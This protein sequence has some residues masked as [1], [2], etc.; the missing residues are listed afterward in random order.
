MIKEELWLF[1]IVFTIG[2][3][4]WNIYQWNDMMFKIGSKVTGISGRGLARDIDKIRLSW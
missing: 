4:C 1:L 3:T 2:D